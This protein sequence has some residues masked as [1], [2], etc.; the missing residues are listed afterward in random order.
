MTLQRKFVRHAVAQILR[1]QTAAGQNVIPGRIVEPE[2][3]TFPLILVYTPREDLSKYD[4]AP[5]RYLRDLTVRVEVLV[6][7]EVNGATVDDQLDD[8]CEQVECIM[9]RELAI[10][11]PIPA[12]I[13][14][15]Q[16][17]EAF[18]RTVDIELV[19]T[20][21]RPHAAAGF[22]YRLPYIRGEKPCDPDDLAP[23]LEAGFKWDLP[24]SGELDAQN[25]VPIPQ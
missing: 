10:L 12:D 18:L 2:S 16:Y 9:E 17:S 22:S 14:E 8:L 19:E 13:L 3:E 23:F 6:R 11:E 25:A 21:N 15:V 1:G 24:P 5:R 20:G 4:E 7:Q